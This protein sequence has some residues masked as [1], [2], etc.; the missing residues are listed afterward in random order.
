MKAI[1]KYLSLSD[2]ARLSRVCH[3]LYQCFKGLWFNSEFFSE[4]DLSKFSGVAAAHRRSKSARSSRS[5]SFRTIRR[6]WATC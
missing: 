1:I 3:F 6:C 4:M 2:I 5:R